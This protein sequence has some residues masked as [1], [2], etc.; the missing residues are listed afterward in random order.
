MRYYV[1]SSRA[2]ESL[3]IVSS[4]TK[5]ECLFLLE[6]HFNKEGIKPK[7]AQSEFAEEFQANRKSYLD[8]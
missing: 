6:N 3:D 4:M 7:L 8:L 2:K 1:G 5:E